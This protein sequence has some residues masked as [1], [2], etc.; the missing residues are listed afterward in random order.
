MK[1]L[2]VH[3][4]ERNSW[5]WQGLNCWIGI[6]KDAVPRL[7][8]N[9]TLKTSSR[10][11]V[12]VWVLLP[13]TC[14]KLG[15]GICS[16]WIPQCRSAEFNERVSTKTDPTTPK[17]MTSSSFPPSLL[18]VFFPSHPCSPLSFFHPHLKLFLNYDITWWD[19]VAVYTLA[20]RWQPS[21]SRRAFCSLFCNSTM[22]SS[23]WNTCSVFSFI[24]WKVV[25]LSHL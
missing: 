2:V 1:L 10:L 9:T 19:V 17:N 14:R 15:P 11:N 16:V 20:S 3:R 12:I 7:W 5:A 18:P 13:K 6:L 22:R 4:G 25:T 21:L 24:V 23:L 8:T